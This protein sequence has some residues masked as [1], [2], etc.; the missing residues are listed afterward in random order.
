MKA[1][2][3]TPSERG[4]GGRESRV[5]VGGRV[6]FCL[7]VIVTCA[8]SDESVMF[9]FGLFFAHL[10]SVGTTAPAIQPLASWRVF[11]TI[12]LL[13]FYCHLPPHIVNRSAG[14]E[15]SR[16]CSFERRGLIGPLIG[17][18]ACTWG[19]T[20]W[21]AFLPLGR[22]TV[23][24]ALLHHMQ[25]SFQDPSKVCGA[26]EV[27]GTQRQGQGGNPSCLISTT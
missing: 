15:L 26:C 6:Y 9:L 17:W 12:L 3:C 11:G 27:P 23:P 16:A 22:Q 19:C 5:G 7:H 1:P 8:A 14:A 24:E 25:P 4:R 21:L 10:F 13:A 18:V 2:V 20:T